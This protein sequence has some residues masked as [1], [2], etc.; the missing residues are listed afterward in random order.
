[1]SNFKV[2]TYRNAKIL[3][4]AQGRACTLC[5]QDDGTIVA[6]HSNLMGDGKGIGHKAG[7][8][9]VAFLCA[10]CHRCYDQKEGV[11]QEDFHRAMK[12]T[13]EILLN[14]GVLK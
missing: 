12:R 10:S 4:A 9:F 1:M 11:T 13:W 2:I 14:D 8:C 3:R 6:A 5:G 7:D